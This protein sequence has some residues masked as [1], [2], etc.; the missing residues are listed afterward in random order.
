[1]IISSIDIDIIFQW[2]KNIDESKTKIQKMTKISKNSFDDFLMWLIWIENISIDYWYDINYVWTNFKHNKYEKIDDWLIAMFIINKT[3][4]IDFNND[5]FDV[6]FHENDH[7][8]TFSHV[9]ISNN[10]FQINFLIEIK[11]SLLFVTLYIHIKI[12]CEKIYI[13]YLKAFV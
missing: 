6:D 2:L 12:I 13:N 11:S 7:K 8:I 4:V 5:E 10:F 1:M 9:M 3:N